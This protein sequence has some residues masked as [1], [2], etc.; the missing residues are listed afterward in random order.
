MRRSRCYSN[1]R[2]QPRP[3]KPAGLCRFQSSNSQGRDPITSQEFRTLQKEIQSLKT[4]LQQ[5]QPSVSSSRSSQ[6]SSAVKQKS[7]T[8]VASNDKIETLTTMTRKLTERT[9]QIEARLDQIHDNMSRIGAL[10]QMANN[11]QEFLQHNSS[12]RGVV[13]NLESIVQRSRPFFTQNKY[14][15]YMILG[16]I[17]L[18]AIL[19]KYRQTIVYDRTSE[20]VADLARRTLEQEVAGR[21]ENY[22]RRNPENAGKQTMN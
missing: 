16:A 13:H 1:I 6:I 14:S 21:I 8:P 22:R 11:A 18:S 7:D 15:K 20:E 19:W 5:L 9:T 2:R 10:E 12:I 4:L 3:V 17:S